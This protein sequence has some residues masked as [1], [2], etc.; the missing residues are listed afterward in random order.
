MYFFFFSDM[1]DD[2]RTDIVPRF[3]VAW[4][5]V[6]QS[7]NKFHYVTVKRRELTFRRPSPHPAPLLFPS[8]LS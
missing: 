5:G 7:D 3:F 2:P 4:P 6:T 8:S 1:A